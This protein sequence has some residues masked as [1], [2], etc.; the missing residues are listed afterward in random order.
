MDAYHRWREVVTPVTVSG[1]PAINVPVGF[2]RRGLP[3]G[4][5]IWGEAREHAVLRLASAYEAA[6]RGVERRVPA[7]LKPPAPFRVAR[8]TAMSRQRAIKL[9]SRA[10]AR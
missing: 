3:M 8:R 4:L 6:T 5:Q 7:L 2:N 1:C 10:E 9:G